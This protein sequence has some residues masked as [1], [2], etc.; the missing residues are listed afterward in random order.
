MFSTAKFILTAAAIHLATASAVAG[1]VSIAPVSVVERPSQVIEAGL[2]D[3]LFG[4]GPAKDSYGPEWDADF[5]T[6][7]QNGGN[8]V[9]SP[10]NN[11]PQDNGG[12]NLWSPDY[13]TPADNGGDNAWSPDYGHN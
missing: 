13:N 12:N 6:P 5:G 3:G 1:P 4:G 7:Q 11:T 10:N 8:N 2:L 9:W